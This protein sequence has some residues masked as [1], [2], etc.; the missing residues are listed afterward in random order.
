MINSDFLNN[1]KNDAVLLNLSR[2]GIMKE[3]DILDHLDKNENFWL[4]LD[5]HLNEPAT[6][7]EHFTN[8]LA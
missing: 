2:G 5:T 1:M 8:N 7:C 3:D 6:G 4:G